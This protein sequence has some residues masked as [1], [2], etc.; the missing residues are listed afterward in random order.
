MQNW[1]IPPLYHRYSLTG[2]KREKDRGRQAEMDWGNSMSANA[3]ILM[4]SPNQKMHKI[5]HIT[6][7]IL[8]RKTKCKL[9]QSRIEVHQLLEAVILLLS[10]ENLISVGPGFAWG[11]CIYVIIWW[12]LKGVHAE[13]QGLEKCSYRN[14]FILQVWFESI[15]G[16]FTREWWF[17][18]FFKH[19][20]TMGW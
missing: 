18:L 2:D 1:S 11:Q 14:I 13:P 7:E 5:F 8:W 10:G 15:Q 9:L 19:H 16:G 3:L 20:F 6:F 17:C 4:L 12:I